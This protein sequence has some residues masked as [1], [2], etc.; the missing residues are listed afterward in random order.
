[1]YE[2]TKITLYYSHGNVIKC[3]DNTHVPRSTLATLPSKLKKP[4]MEENIQ[5]Y[6]TTSSPNTIQ[7]QKAHYG[8]TQ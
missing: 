5:A 4:G 6:T 1:M 7:A 3:C 8:W 2:R